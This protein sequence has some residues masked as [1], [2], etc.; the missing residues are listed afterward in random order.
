[1]STRFAALVGLTLLLGGCS[2][3]PVAEPPAPAADPPPKDR[4]G[5]GVSDMTDACPDMPGPSSRDP[6][7]HGCPDELSGK[8]AAGKGDQDSDGIPDAA[9]KCPSEAEDKDAFQDEDGC[10]DPDNDNDGVVDAVDHCPNEP[11]GKNPDRA[12]PGCPGKAAVAITKSTIQITQQVHF[13]SG[14]AAIGPD[15]A[16]LLDALV[17]VLR[18]N[19]KV[20]V[21]VEGHNDNQ[22][23]DVTLSWRRARAVMEKL[24]ASGVSP[25]RLAYVGYGRD[26]PIA[27]NS[28]AV[29]RSSNRR[30]EFQVDN[31]E[32]RKPAQ[33]TP[34]AAPT[35]PVGPA[36][37]VQPTGPQGL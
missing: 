27:D 32:G 7:K 15:S 26:K 10:P 3:V 17:V 33:P 8:K 22:E 36:Q 28:N 34:P 29:G 14:S 20:A 18:G 12:K 35:A 11:A 13:S 1:M 5:D 37:P 2:A 25:D 21:K 30:V 9:D 19:P 4:D 16:T 6:R 31:A 24:I 23:L